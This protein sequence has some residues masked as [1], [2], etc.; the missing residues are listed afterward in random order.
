MIIFLSDLQKEHL[1]LLH[2][3]SAQVLVDFC[4][5]TIDF[6]NN[7]INQKKC[8]IAAERLN[9]P[10]SVIQNLIYA[11]AYLLVEGCKHNLLETNF[12]S[13]LAIAGFSPEHQQVLLKL[14]NTKKKEI[15]EALNLLQQSEASYQ[16]LLWRFEI[17]VA[18]QNSN[19]EIIPMVAMDF[20]LSTPKKVSE[21][22]ED[23]SKVN[24]ESSTISENTINKTIEDAKTASE[25]QNIISHVLLQCDLPNLLHLTNRLEEALKESKS[26]HVRK[27]QRAL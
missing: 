2:E 21:H 4:K 25:C 17:Q 11:L 7:G 20:V 9:V 5:L 22:N 19:E 24:K 3:H 6:L 15:S 12:N 27:V 14:Y 16:D 13:S 1:K 26:Q 8:A 18:S 23:H 10:P